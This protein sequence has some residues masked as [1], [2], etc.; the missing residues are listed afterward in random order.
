MMAR[1]RA[2]DRFKYK[3]RLGVLLAESWSQWS[4][5]AQ[6]VVIEAV[7][8]MHETGD[9]RAD[10]LDRALLTDDEFLE[11]YGRPRPG[12]GRLG[13]RGRARP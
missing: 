2:I 5:D 1:A 6:D 10:W 8:R 7:V 12:A 4:P 13:G 9:L 3:A 11:K